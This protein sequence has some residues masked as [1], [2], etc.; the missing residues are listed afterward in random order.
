M[1]YIAGLLDRY[2]LKNRLRNDSELAEALG[3][4]KASVSRWR[5]GQGLPEPWIAFDIA[6]N[7]G[8]EPLGLL[9]RLEADRARNK[10]NRAVWN[11]ILKNAVFYPVN[12]PINLI[13]KT[14]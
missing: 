6:D 12:E 11:K 2:K 4:T 7:I 8:V 1:S 14:G 9:I 10:D 3:V 5:S 13:K